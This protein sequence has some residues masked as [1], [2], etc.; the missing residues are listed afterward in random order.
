MVAVVVLIDVMHAER[1][2]QPAADQGQRLPAPGIGR[3]VNEAR[4]EIG[5]NRAH[6]EDD[7]QPPFVRWHPEHSDELD[8][9]QKNGRGNGQNLCC[10]PPETDV[11]VSR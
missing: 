4:D 8:R 1:P 3:R 9:E 6:D 11:I 5:P 10:P 7:R 2:K